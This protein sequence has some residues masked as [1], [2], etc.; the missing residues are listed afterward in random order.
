MRVVIFNRS[1]DG[2]GIIIS[3]GGGAGGGLFQRVGLYGVGGEAVIAGG[4]D[5]RVLIPLFMADG[6]FLVF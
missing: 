2:A 5:R 6:A 4:V 3:G 1:A